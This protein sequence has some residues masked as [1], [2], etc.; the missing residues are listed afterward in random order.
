MLRWASCLTTCNLRIDCNKTLRLAS[1]NNKTSSFKTSCLKTSCG[2]IYLIQ[3]ATCVSTATRHGIDCNKTRYRLQQDTVSTATRHGIDCNKTWY[4]L[5]QDT[6]SC[7][8]R[9]NNKISYLA[10]S[11]LPFHSNLY[12][13][14]PLQ[15]VRAIL[16]ICMSAKV[17]EWRKRPGDANSKSIHIPTPKLYVDRH[18]DIKHMSHQAQVAHKLTHDTRACLIAHKSRTSRAHVA[19]K[20][21]CQR[22]RRAKVTECA[23]AARPKNR[24]YI[25]MSSPYVL[26]IYIHLNT[27]VCIST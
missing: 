16:I 3:P 17:T 2:L 20:S 26:Y 6:V 5:H 8:A 7:L 13:L 4:R 10:T 24:W 21:Q 1:S 23:R 25:C 15:S 11:N 12:P 27:G 14:K 18:V 19:H 22:L 9:T